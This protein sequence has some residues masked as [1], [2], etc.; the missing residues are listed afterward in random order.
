MKKLKLGSVMGE[1]FD[2]KELEDEGIYSEEGVTELLNDDE[3][4]PREA[5]FMHGYDAYE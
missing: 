2:I 3:L 1:E 4:T 5:A